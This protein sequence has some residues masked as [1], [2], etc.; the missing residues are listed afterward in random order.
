MKRLTVEPAKDADLITIRVLGATPQEAAMLANTVVTSYRYVVAKQ[1]DTAAKQAVAALAR[2]QRQLEGEIA[3]LDEQ[4]KTE[5]GNPRLQANRDAKIRQLDALA[6]Q[7]EEARR[8]S[9][10]AG[11]TA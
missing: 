1:A 4:L 5:P 11:R 2:R 7:G 9:A 3:T 8:D 6:D 10:R